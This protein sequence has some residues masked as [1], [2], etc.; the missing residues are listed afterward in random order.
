M[1][2]SR[3]ALFAFAAVLA[4]G[5]L[6]VSTQS[7]EAKGLGLDFLN[8][9]AYTDCLKGISFLS[10]YNN[11]RPQSAAERDAGYERGRHYCNRQ[12]GYEH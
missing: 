10:G 4:I 6:A 5:S 8:N 3:L 12:A 2:T 7:S 11:G 1:T 9:K